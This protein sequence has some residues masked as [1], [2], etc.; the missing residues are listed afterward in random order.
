MKDKPVAHGI[1]IDVDDM[2]AINW[3]V[4]NLFGFQGWSKF[5]YVPPS[6]VYEPLVRMIYANLCSSKSDKLESVVL[7]KHIV[8]DYAMLDYI[9]QCKC[10]G[11][12][13]HFKNSWPNDFEIS[14]DRAKR[15]I[16][17]CP[18]DFLPSEL[19]HSDV[20]FETRVLDYIVAT[21]LF[22]HTKSFSTFSQ[23]DTFSCLLYCDQIQD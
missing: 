23:R 13:M 5:L 8:L 1:I 20:S 22:P 12:P 3:K 17:E 15:C 21:T 16:A 7:G 19:G 10:Y 4:K 18:S 6:E 9:F 14:F 2:E 11:F